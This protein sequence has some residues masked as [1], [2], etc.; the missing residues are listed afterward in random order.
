MEVPSLCDSGGLVEP[1]TVDLH[2]AGVDRTIVEDDRRRKSA[3]EEV[4]RDGGPQDD[5]DMWPAP[6]EGVDDFDLPRRVAEA[7]AADVEGDGDQWLAGSR[8]RRHY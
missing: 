4:P 7:V 5:A 3:I 2:D 1:Q 6:R 8:A